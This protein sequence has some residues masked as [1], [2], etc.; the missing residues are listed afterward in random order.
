MK[1][2]LIQQWRHFSD[3]NTH[4]LITSKY[5][6]TGIEIHVCNDDNP[7]YSLYTMT[8]IELKNMI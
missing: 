2:T 1:G 5:E 4:S 8:E 6:C 3:I 7:Y